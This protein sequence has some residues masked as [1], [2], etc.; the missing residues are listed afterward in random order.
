MITTKNVLGYAKD[1]EKEC[2]KYPEVV[3]IIHILG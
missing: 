3:I 2:G 1:I